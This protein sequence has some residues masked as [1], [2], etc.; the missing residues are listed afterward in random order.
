MSLADEDGRTLREGEL[1]VARGPWTNVYGLSRSLLA[2]GTLLTLTFNRTNLLFR[3]LG[4]AVVPAPNS[5]ARFGLFALA[6]PAQL[7]LANNVSI[8]VLILVII[9][10][11]PR[12]TGIL[13]WWVTA[14]FAAA[15]VPVE[16]G[17]QVAAILSLLLIPISLGDG[18]RWHWASQEAAVTTLVDKIGASVAASCYGAIRLQVCVIYFFACISKFAV[19]EWANGTAVYYWLI[20]PTFGVAH[21]FRP[22]VIAVLA[23]PLAM[24]LVTWSVLVMEALLFSG[25][26]MERRHRPLLLIAGLVFHFGIGVAHGLFTFSLSMAAALILYL[27]DPAE[28][29]TYNA[30]IH[31]S[32]VRCAGRSRGA[33]GFV[34]GVTQDSRARIT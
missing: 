6:E 27:R 12:F 20:H 2:F 30:W 17:D 29:F 26:V 23:R 10:W 24:A 31:S 32:A 21:V 3:P 13:H 15:C 7:A 1:G 14:S 34:G 22:L 25:L 9:G 18:R 11:R 19:T 8:G 4:N 16:G 33:I 5:L 28:P